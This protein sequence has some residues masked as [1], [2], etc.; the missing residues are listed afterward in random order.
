MTKQA[1]PISREL[2][3]EIVA[4]II[5]G[6]VFFFSILSIFWFQWYVPFLLV[7]DF[8]LRGFLGKPSPL[9]FLAIGFHKILRKKGKM[10]NAGPKKFAMQIGF[11]VSVLMTFFAFF[12][13][14]L[15][16]QIT[17]TLLAL[18][19]GLELFFDFCLGCKMFPYW[20]ILKSWFVRKN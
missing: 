9:K 10:V 3:N 15:A 5:S 14:V 20:Q 19:S 18:A 11:W 16:F 17:S 2:V 12:D 1:C 8:F 13:F 6:E 7:F 4:K